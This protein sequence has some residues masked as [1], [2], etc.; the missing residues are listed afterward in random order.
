VAAPVAELR[1]GTVGYDTDA[2]PAIMAT[3]NLSR[4]STYRESV[5]TSAESAVRKARVAVA[6]G[7]ALV[8]IGAE[9]TTARAQRVTADEQIRQLVPVVEACAAE[10]I[11]VSV[12]TYEPEVTRACLRAGAVV[13]NMTGSGH[14]EQMFEL[15]AEHGATLVLCYTA[16]ADVRQITDIGLGADPIPALIE[17]FAARAELARTYGVTDLVLDPGMGF[18]YG[19]LT[20]PLTRARHQTQVILNSFRLRVLG[21]PVCHALPHAFDLF[22]EQFRSAEGF[23]AVLARLGGAGML[24]THEVPLAVAVA[25]AMAVLDVSDDWSG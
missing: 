25:G 6:Q 12:E 5:A 18:Y 7:A 8:D 11:A 14:Q 19:N 17:H 24:R 21:L 10:S 23:F 20:D 15:A 3:V 2:A 13:L 16:G 4:D 9:S 1:I 22:E